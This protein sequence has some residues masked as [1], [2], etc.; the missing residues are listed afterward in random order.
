M[1]WLQSL[2]ADCTALVRGQHEV[3]AAPAVE[4]PA[5]RRYKAP[6][7]LTPR[8]LE[9]Y[10]KVERAKRI[11]MGVLKAEYW[12]WRLINERCPETRLGRWQIRVTGRC[13]VFIEEVE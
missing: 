9:M 11:G 3:F 4:A 6:A 1:N 5:P 7:G 10:E 8:L 2:W 13:E 12:L